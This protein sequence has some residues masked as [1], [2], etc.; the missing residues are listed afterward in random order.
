MGYHSE[1]T[2]SRMMLNIEYPDGRK[3]RKIM[4]DCGYYQEIAYRH[5]NYEHELNPADIDVIIIS[6]NHIDHT[7]LLPK[8]VS[9]GYIG[10]IYMTNITRE[11]LPAYLVDSAKQQPENA[12]YLRKRYRDDAYKFRTLY[13]YADV[14]KVLTLTIGVNYRKK[15]EVLPGVYVTFFENGHLLGAACVLVQ[16]TC[17]GKN[18]INFF[19]TGDYRSRNPLFFVPTIPRWVKKLELNI[20]CESTYGG[21]ESTEIHPCFEKNMMEAFA[22]R[23]NIL[24]GAFSQ[25]RY[26]EIL[27]FYRIMQE[28]GKIPPEYE[29]CIDGALGISTCWKYMSILKRYYPN[30]PN[31]MPEGIRV[32][33]DDTRNCIL[34]DVMGRKTRIILITTSGMLSN[35][36]A[37]VH[38]PNFIERP[39][40][41]IHL[42]G[43]AAEETIA[44]QL[45]DTIDKDKVRL[46]GKTYHRRATV[47]TTREFSRHAPA[48]ELIKF[49]QEFKTVRFVA[50]N[51][52][53]KSQAAEFVKRVV[54]ECPNVE[55]VGRLNR[56]T[57][58]CFIQKAKKGS[59]DENIAVKA[60]PAK[61]CSSFDTCKQEKRQN[62][63]KKTSKDT[64][65][66]D[67][68][69][70][71][72]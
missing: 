72:R 13:T 70:R 5:L 63:Y 27:Y 62:T 15:I 26:Q 60:L 18:P 71:R 20:V 11:L 52:G 23:M 67:R 43:Y 28:E 54:G 56:Q 33:D 36:P 42:C 2:G 68:R 29:I 55:E 32:L 35:G 69:E 3:S 10:P 37:R 39:D 64:K 17:Y 44:R 38:V 16:I 59:M 9:E 30:S 21:V 48:D 61:L 47:R 8:M 46:W 53:S 51:H 14:D 24:D 4:F 49:L 65:S 31:F 57:M 7:G 19:F 58:F 41:M 1:V 50:V 22:K 34:G 66:C 12:E 45:L 40:C 25:G 6:H